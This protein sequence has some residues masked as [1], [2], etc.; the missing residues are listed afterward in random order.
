MA[1]A[2]PLLLAPAMFS[3]DGWSYAAQG[4][5]TRLG[6]RLMPGAMHPWMDPHRET[7]LW[8]HEN[9]EV[10]RAFDTVRNRIVA[11]KR[12]PRQLGVDAEYR[13]RF[14][15]EAA[16]VVQLMVTVGLM[17]ASGRSDLFLFGGT[18]KGWFVE[19]KKD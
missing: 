15:R 13:A 1:W 17:L 8:P 5:L 3:R 16:L 10:Y 4:E 2:A 11:L 9:T 18:K 6:A 14:Q 7:E 19:S 12:L